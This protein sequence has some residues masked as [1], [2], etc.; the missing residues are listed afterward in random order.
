MATSPVTPADLYNLIKSY[1]DQFPLPAPFVTVNVG[2]FDGA[3][4]TFSGLTSRTTTDP[5]PVAH[6]PNQKPTGKAYFQGATYVSIDVSEQWKSTTTITPAPEVPLAPVTLQFSITNFAAGWSVTVNA[7]TTSVPAGQASVSISIWDATAATWS[8]EAGGRTHGDRLMIQRAAGTMGVIAGAFT[9]P[10]LPVTIVYAPPKDSLGKSFASYTQGQTI[11]TTITTTFGT[12]SSTTS[13]N[14]QNAYGTAQEYTDAVTVAGQALGLAGTGF[15]SES[16][17]LGDIASELGK[18]SS[19]TTKDLSQTTDNSLT[20]TQTITQG[21]ETVP[22]EG[23]PG[24]GDV[25]M[26]ARNVLMAWIGTGTQLLLF[27]FSFDVVDSSAAGLQ[28]NP[29]GLLITQA[30]AQ[31]LLSFDPFAGG[32]AFAAVD[33]TRFQ[34]QESLQYAFGVEVP[35]TETVTRGSSTTTTNK[36]VTT[37]TN[38]WDAGPLFQMLGLGGKTS[39]SVTTGSATGSSVSS[40]VTIAG[41]LFAGPTDNF[42]VNIYY[43][44]T[45][46]TFAFQQ[47]QP[48][49]TPVLSGS[50][51]A[52]GQSVTLSSGGRIFR[53]VTDSNAKY[54]FL[55]RSIPPGPA[56]LTIGNQAPSKVN[57]AAA[58]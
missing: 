42:I 9:I 46:G 56:T 45:F 32:G 55:S 4:G 7:V 19:T 48:A 1:E 20:F 40:T 34:L 36:S 28:T 18:F 22:Q 2:T 27:P 6:E 8:I 12:E 21:L 30:D 39:T 41:T 25:I 29:A 15:A 47:E 37:E 50:G 3:T 31:F 43:D 49:A 33:P 51:T 58:S 10:A 35:L 26:F 11:G 54:A 24:A 14:M 38:E 17:A 53:T 16:K 23:G 44:T 52:A 5:E 57:V 13:P